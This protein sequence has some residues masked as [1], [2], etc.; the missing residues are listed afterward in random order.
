VEVDGNNAK[1]AEMKAYKSWK[2]GEF[3]LDTSYP[4]FICEEADLIEEEEENA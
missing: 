2:N 1:E 3:F 4:E